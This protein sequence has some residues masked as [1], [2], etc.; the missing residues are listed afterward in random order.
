MDIRRAYS[1]GGLEVRAA[2]DGRREITGVAIRYGSITQ[3][4]L[5]F[6]FQER[7]AAGAFTRSLAKPIRDITANWNH[8]RT[9]QLGSKAAGT[10]SFRDSEEALYFSVRVFPQFDWVVDL[11]ES[12][13]AR[14]ASVEFAMPEYEREMYDGK[15]LETITQAEL[16]GVAVV[17][18]PAYEDAQVDYVKR[19]IDEARQAEDEDDDEDDE[20]DRKGDHDKDGDERAQQETLLIIDDILGRNQIAPYG[21]AEEEASDG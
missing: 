10:L 13:E 5:G 14:G 18:A 4:V 7:F 20:E 21:D 16:R 11:V 9:F 17:N 1:D 15:V 12:G 6:E 19:S 3:P 2:A 8:N